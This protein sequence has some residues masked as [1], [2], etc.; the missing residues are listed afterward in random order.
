[1]PRK[2]APAPHPKLYIITVPPELTSPPVRIF[3]IDTPELRKYVSTLQQ[4]YRFARKGDPLPPTSR[5]KLVDE[6]RR[7]VFNANHITKILLGERGPW[8]DFGDRRQNLP[9]MLGLIFRHGH[10]IQEREV[11]RRRVTQRNRLIQ[12]LINFFR[13][14]MQE[15]LDRRDTPRWRIERLC[16]D[17]QEWIRTLE[18]WKTP[19]RYLQFHPI[20]WLGITVHPAKNVSRQAFWSRSIVPLYRYLK[21]TTDES[22]GQ[23]FR[24]IARILHLASHKLYPDD[25]KRVKARYYSAAGLTRRSLARV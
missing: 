1:M 25:W 17:Y 10:R 12:G 20:P 2:K 4:E 13:R 8:F 7:G 11:L 22:E 16:R 6:A 14:E 18:G 3:P 19:L 24:M 5:R 23:I 9:F 15:A 21:R